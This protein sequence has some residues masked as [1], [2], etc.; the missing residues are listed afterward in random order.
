MLQKELK[1]H[2]ELVSIAEGF[3]SHRNFLKEQQRRTHGMALSTD[4]SASSQST[5][6]TYWVATALVENEQHGMMLYRIES[7]GDGKDM[8][9]RSFSY[10]DSA[11]KYLLLS[12]LARHVDQVQQIELRLPPSALPETWLPDLRFTLS[13][14]EA[15]MG[16]IVTVAG[17]NGMRCGPGCFSARI[18]D[19]D[20]P[21]NNSVYLFEAVDDILHVSEVSTAQCD[22]TIQGLTALIY[23]THEPETFAI[24][25][26]G[27]PSLELQAMMSTM[28]P[29][30]LPYLYEKY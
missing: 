10:T 12:W 16:R 1:G 13:A 24:R 19:P 3:S 5:E 9:V 25:G 2:V 7:N 21:W 28:F 6:D 29:P 15:P 4:H 8:K 23:G 20:C 30:L 17:I 27:D 26:W 22:L 11:G 18:I 14:D